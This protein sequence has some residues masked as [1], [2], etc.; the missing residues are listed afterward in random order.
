MA[1]AFCFTAAFLAATATSVNAQ[2]GYSET[3]LVSDVPGQAQF[4]DPNLVNPWGLAAVNAGDWWVSDNNSGLTTL[5][6]GNGNIQSLVVTVPPGSS[7][8]TS[9]G[10]PTGIVGNTTSDFGGSFFIFDSEDGTISAWFGAGSTVTQIDKGTAAVYK[11]LAMASMGTVNVLYAANFRAGTVEAYDLDFNPFTLSAGA[12]TDPKIPAG[13]APFG[14]QTIKGNLYVTFAKQDASKHDQ[15]NGP[16]LGYVDEFDPTGKLIMRLQHVAEMNAPWGTALAGT[17]FGTFSG[18]LLIGNFGSGE[19]A[20]FSP[21]TGKFIGVV[22][23]STGKPIVIKGLWALQFGQ[24]GTS[25]PTDWLYFTAGP[26]NEA[27]GLFGFLSPL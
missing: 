6:D 20:A 18:D 5:Y 2:T 17:N 16:G 19:I 11:G 14:I 3:R 24:G 9:K 23:G 27:H 13:Y 22:T 7:D 26:K 8:P 1:A 10:S 12:F 4:T 25:G 21:T 15:L